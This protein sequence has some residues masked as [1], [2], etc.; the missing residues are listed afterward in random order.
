MTGQWYIS[1]LHASRYP[2]QVSA[3]VQKPVDV[4]RS[5]H[6][7]FTSESYLPSL[8]DSPFQHME[9]VMEMQL[10]DPLTCLERIA[11]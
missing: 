3:N 4:L 8:L 2:L 11:A 5:E 7:S 1:A 6:T 9:R 10:A